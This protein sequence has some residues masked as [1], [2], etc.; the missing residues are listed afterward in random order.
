MLITEAVTGYKDFYKMPPPEDEFSLLRSYPTDLIIMELAKVNAILFQEMGSK[1]EVLAKILS[2]VFPMLDEKRR[3]NVFREMGVSEKLEFLP[4]LF[5]SPPISKLIGLC[6]DNYY[7]VSTDEV[8]NTY[9]F[10]QDLFDSILIANQRY[11]NQ[12]KGEDDVNT[13]EIQWKLGLMQQYY[14]R[15]FDYI[16]LTGQTKVLLFH[17]FI[18]HHFPEGQQ[19]IKEFTD[20][21]GSNGFFSPA[22][23]A[24]EL[25]SKSLNN[26]Q[27]DK[28]PKW[29]VVFSESLK[30]MMEHFSLR[31]TEILEGKQSGHVHKNIM[32]HPFYYLLNE[33]AV[34]LDYDYLAYIV[35]FS[36]TY[37]FYNFTSLNGSEKYKT[38]NSFKSMLGKSYY[39][40]FI[41]GEIIRKVFASKGYQ[42]FD[43][44]KEFFPDFTICH[45][46]ADMVLMEVKSAEL[47]IEALENCDA[48]RV[49]DFL[50]V[51]FAG[52]K[53][54]KERNKGIYQ[55]IESIRQLAESN[56]L[57]SLLKSPDNKEKCTLYP[58]LIYTDHVFDITWINGYLNNIFEEEIK[59]YKKYFKKIYP[60][61]MINQS[62]LIDKYDLLKDDPKLLKSWI[63]QYWKRHQSNI[64]SFRKKR[65]PNQFLKAGTSFTFFLGDILP[66]RNGLEFFRRIAD[67][68]E[69][70][71]VI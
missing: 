67:D 34:V 17:K 36:L 30:K 51:Q 21:M 22:L 41:T 69:L 63:E 68:L 62:I 65:D 11:Y 52:K 47:N 31:P 39:E 50:D 57:D 66:Q 45:Y 58:T 70:K 28:K 42:V 55:L 23:V 53:Q 37:N 56:K 40:D 15:R 9:Q 44:R 2:E 16:S 7:Y 24:M 8:V 12:V 71:E 49:K 59:P 10:Q 60:L 38:F 3:R 20:A 19:L 54:G 18:W 64:Q 61:T 27:I 26:Y 1:N 43:D 48:I 32:T 29:S 5:A 13:Y 33:Y 25:V 46:D 6:F 4:N 35:E 14:I